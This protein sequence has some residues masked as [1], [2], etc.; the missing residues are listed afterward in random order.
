VTLAILLF[1]QAMILRAGRAAVCRALEV[2]QIDDKTAGL[3]RA[4]LRVNT[5]CI[6][7]EKPQ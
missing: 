7:L 1:G 4:R 5:L 2:D 3:L 6:L